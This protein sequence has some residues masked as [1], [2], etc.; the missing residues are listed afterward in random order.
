MLKEAR[1]GQCPP[2]LGVV[3]HA[4]E[5]VGHK[6]V[7]RA[8]GGDG[9]ASSGGEA[10]Y[11]LNFHRA[12]KGE[13]SLSALPSI[14]PSFWKIEASNRPSDFTI[15]QRKY[16]RPRIPEADVMGFYTYWRERLIGEVTPYG[17]EHYIFVPLLGKLRVKKRGDL[18]SQVDMIDA[19]LK[20]A[21]ERLFVIK[22]EPERKYDEA[23]QEILHKWDLNP[24]IILRSSGDLDRFIAAASY[25]VSINSAASLRALFH[26]KQSLLFSYCDC[27]HINRLVKNARSFDVALSKVFEVTPSY[28]HYLYWYF[29]MNC[30]DMSYGDT[31]A[32]RQAI[33]D[34]CRALG[35]RV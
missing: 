33:L 31:P 17:L 10:R 28:P 5:E 21:P 8:S 35:W 22:T 16:Q 13:G 2:F 15:T 20:R 24:Q 12:V 29:V 1:A 30:L 18:F 6:V 9:A 19:M 7:L 34:R 23:E 32:L 14:L 3:R 11:R 27:H 26:S 4:F 25:L